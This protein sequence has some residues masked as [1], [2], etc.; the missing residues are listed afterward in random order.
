[1]LKTKFVVD[2]IT[3]DYTMQNI[4]PVVVVSRV[5]SFL[6]FFEELLCQIHSMVVAEAVFIKREKTEDESD[7]GSGSE[8][9]LETEEL[10]G[11]TNNTAGAPRVTDKEKFTKRA[12]TLGT[13]G[14][15]LVSIAFSPLFEI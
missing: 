2:M 8:G 14:R 5:S 15:E 10:E 6:R 12:M 1:M 4:K 9:D 13:K 11:A 3:H 7:D